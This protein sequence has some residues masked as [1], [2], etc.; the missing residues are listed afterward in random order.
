MDLVNYITLEVTWCLNQ[1]HIQFN[2]QVSLTATT[3]I[4]NPEYKLQISGKPIINE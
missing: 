4:N 3:L 1:F 2:K